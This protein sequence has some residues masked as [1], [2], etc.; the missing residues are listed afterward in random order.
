MGVAENV[1]PSPHLTHVPLMT[2]VAPRNI[3][4]TVPRAVLPVPLVAHALGTPDIWSGGRADSASPRQ[5]PH[6]HLEDCPAGAIRLRTS[7]SWSATSGRR[8][9]ARDQLQNDTAKKMFFS[10]RV[11]MPR[12]LSS[13]PR[14]HSP[15]SRSAPPLS[16]QTSPAHRPPRAP[17]TSYWIPAPRADA[18][19]ARLSPH[20][21]FVFSLVLLKYPADVTHSAFTR[22]LS[23]RRI[24]G[25][26]G[27]SRGGGRGS[28]TALEMTP[29][30]YS[31]L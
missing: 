18:S 29:A 12:V 1:P 14:V 8:G 27:L 31:Q 15:A 11:Q 7:A 6:Q 16:P 20:A 24:A 5:A 4:P 30:V 13:A 9:S 28:F 17:P 26:T 2:C 10:Y 21:R 3:V 23:R 19:C 25:L 22:L